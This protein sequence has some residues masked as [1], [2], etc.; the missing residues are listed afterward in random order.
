VKPPGSR[1]SRRG[2]GS[3][4]PPAIL[5][6]DEYLDHRQTRFAWAEEAGLVRGTAGGL[7]VAVDPR[8]VPLL[9]TTPDAEPVV[10]AVLQLFDGEVVAVRPIPGKPT[11]DPD[12]GPGVAR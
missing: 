1:P 4:S 3:A 2:A 10:S 8:V 12:S 5:A 11:G 6:A 9:R 7:A